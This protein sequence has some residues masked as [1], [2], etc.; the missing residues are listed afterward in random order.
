M[1]TAEEAKENLRRHSLDILHTPLGLYAD[2]EENYKD[3]F[4]EIN[5]AVRRESLIGHSTIIVCIRTLKSVKK[6]VDI[7]K[8]A[9]FLE[10][11]G[12][13]VFINGSIEDKQV[14]FVVE[15]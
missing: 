5:W 12:F 6:A 3:L 9:D 2:P 8:M 10:G 13:T 11:Q 1:I 14:E 7:Y 15:W 4:E